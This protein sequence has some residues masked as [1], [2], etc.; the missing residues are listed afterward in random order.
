MT[1]DRIRVP[2]D[3]QYEVRDRRDTKDGRGSIEAWLPGWHWPVVRAVEHAG[4]WLVLA[5]PK[6][7]EVGGQGNIHMAGGEVAG[8]DDAMQWVNVLAALYVKA[9]GV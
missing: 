8:A 4:R 3:P 6:V 2:G 7:A 9:A 1:I 5:D